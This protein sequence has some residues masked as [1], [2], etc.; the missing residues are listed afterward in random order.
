V[1]EANDAFDGEKPQASRKHAHGCL[2]TC[3]SD[4]WL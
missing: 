4:P 3:A 1:P 2:G